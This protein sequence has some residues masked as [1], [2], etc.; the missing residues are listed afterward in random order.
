MFGKKQIQRTC[1]ACKNVW[2]VDP[3]LRNV[4]I[5][6][7]AGAWGRAFTPIY[8]LEEATQKTNMALKICSCGRCGSTSYK[9]KEVKI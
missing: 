3:K 4:A 2:L 7:Q 9:E 1:Q 6:K 5:P 8:K